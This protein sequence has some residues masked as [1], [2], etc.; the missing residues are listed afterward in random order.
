MLIQKNI[1]L[2]PYSTYKIGGEAK[3]LSISK[4]EDQMLE[5]LRFAKSKNIKYLIIGGGSNILFSDKGFDGLVIINRL[6]QINYQNDRV[7]V[8]SGTIFSL[9]IKQALENNL[10]GMEKLFGIPGTIGGAIFQNAGAYN[11]EIG[12]LVEEVKIIN[13]NIEIE[14]KTRKDMCFSYR[15]SIIKHNNDIVL[16]VTLKLKKIS[17]NDSGKKLKEI[18]QTRNDDKPY[19]KSAGSFFKNPPNEKK[20]WEL[21]DECGFRGF[22]LGYCKVSEKHTNFI[23]NEGNATSKEILELTSKIK[24]TVYDKTKIRLEEEVQIIPF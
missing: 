20:A 4:T 12:D 9:L 3:Y 10:G 19:G 2:A 8:G 15:D 17:Q 14:S 6:N 1:I 24:Q 23:I 18:M 21:I 22:E 5:S 13:D 7:V 16:E 11:T